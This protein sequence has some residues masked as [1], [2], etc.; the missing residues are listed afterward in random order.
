MLHTSAFE[1]RDRQVRNHRLLINQISG[2]GREPRESQRCVYVSVDDENTIV[3]GLLGRACD[4]VSNQEASS[5]SL[6]FY[7]LFRVR[8]LNFPP[9]APPRPRR[10][11]PN[12]S[13]TERRREQTGGTVRAC[14]VHLLTVNT[15]LTQIKPRPLTLTVGDQLG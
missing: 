3:I 11:L 13:H 10:P 8:P 14:S 5:P 12:V 6:R 15:Y 7:F 2:K 9:S 4:P 1:I